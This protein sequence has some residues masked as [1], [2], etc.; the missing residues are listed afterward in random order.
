MPDI[1]DGIAKI[2][3][4]FLELNME[5]PT[6]IHL[7]SHDEGFKFLS[8]VRL[9]NQ[10]VATVGDGSLGQPKRYADGTMYMEVEVMGI[11]VRWPANR[12]AKP[13]GSYCF[14]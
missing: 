7:K 13:D 5:P 11:K 14:V 2:R 10:W 6:A 1:M 9:Q 4:A 3:I 12:Y 8:E